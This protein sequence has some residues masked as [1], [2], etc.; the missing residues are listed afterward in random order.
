MRLA[1]FFLI[2]LVAGCSA[3]PPPAVPLEQPPLRPADEY[4]ALREQA[5]QGVVQVNEVT[6]QKEFVGATEYVILSDFQFSP[7]EL[8]FRSG[9]V[10]RVRLSNTALV[11]HY[12]GGEE[13]FRLGAEPVNLMGSFV[14]RGQHHIPVAPLTDRDIFLFI[15]DPGV[16]LLD[17]FVPNHRAAG[18]VG[19]LVVDP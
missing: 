4:R 11:T 14:P 10:V 7:A 12:F 15:K 2:V 17:C 1:F 6:G 16:Y 13:F 18:M 3:A 9:T 5:L 19:R 8:H